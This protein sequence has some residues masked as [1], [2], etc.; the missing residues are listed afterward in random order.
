MKCLITKTEYLSCSCASG[1]KGCSPESVAKAMFSAFRQYIQSSEYKSTLKSIRIVIF[2]S[3]MVKVFV[4][5][6]KEE[7]KT[8]LSKYIF[9]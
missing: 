8:P 2:Q 3:E 5:A 6:S 7:S 4:G 1:G 9:C